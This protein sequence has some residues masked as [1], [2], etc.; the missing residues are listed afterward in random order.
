MLKHVWL[1]SSL[2]SLCRNGVLSQ[3]ETTKGVTDLTALEPGL[4]S[5][6]KDV[7]KFCLQMSRGIRTLLGWFREYKKGPVRKQ[8]AKQSSATQLAALDAV[9][10]KMILANKKVVKDQVNVTPKK[11]SPSL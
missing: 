9:A 7:E 8:L 11:T 2:V 3:V 10:K 4:V 5:D 1:A 6:V